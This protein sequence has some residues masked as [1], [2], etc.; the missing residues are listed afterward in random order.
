MKTTIVASPAFELTAELIPNR[1]GVNLTLSTH[2]PIANHPVAVPKLLVN[3]SPAELSGF[4]TWIQEAAERFAPEQDE[5]SV[6]EDQEDFSFDW[7]EVDEGD[8]LTPLGHKDPETRRDLMDIKVPADLD[9][10]TL[11]R[12]L[13]SNT[14]I[15]DWAT[16][17]AVQEAENYL[18]EMRSL[19]RKLTAAERARV[20]QAHDQIDSHG[21]NWRDWVE[22]MP[23]DELEGWVEAVE[24]WLKDGPD[25]EEWEHL[26]E[27]TTGQRIAYRYFDNMLL[28]D[29]EAL[30]VVTVEG[31]HPG[32]SY[33]AAELKISPEEANQAA[34][35]F[36]LA[37]RFC[38]PGDRITADG[39]IEE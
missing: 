38:R 11:L 35:E 32:S 8:T 1:A 22:H 36:G 39:A 28:S 3:L 19:E 33:I 34:L 21:E 18:E 24:Y 13:A 9:N 23:S 10:A 4:A 2:I 30:G 6:A 25:V 20:Q 27:H 7:F 17:Q 26:P 16:N 37:C 29:L 15:S 31:D 14:P 5:D 12:I